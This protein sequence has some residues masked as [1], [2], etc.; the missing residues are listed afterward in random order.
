MTG[1]APPALLSAGV[2]LSASQDTCA[3]GAEDP[4]SGLAGHS[5]VPSEAGLAAQKHETQ[6]VDHTLQSS[7]TQIGIHR[8]EWH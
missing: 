8:P 4:A 7:D 5:H 2:E 3:K 6:A 1:A